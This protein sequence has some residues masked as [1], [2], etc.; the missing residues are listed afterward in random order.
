M[1]DNFIEQWV[2]RE[3]SFAPALRSRELCVV[4]SDGVVTLF[5]TV[6]DEGSMRAAER[7]AKQAPNVGRVVNRIRIKPSIVVAHPAPGGWETKP[8]THAAVGR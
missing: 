6:W 3:L 8:G 5:G 1:T 7:A 2:L 4:C